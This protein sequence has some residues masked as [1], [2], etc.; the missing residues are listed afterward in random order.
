MD[1]LCIRCK[2]KGLCGKRCKILSKFME[3]TPK[4]KTHFSGSSPP[5]VFVG[6]ASYPNVFSGILSPTIKGNTEFMSS[7][8]IWVEKNLSI[9][10]VLELR[11]QMIYGR[12][13]GN[14]HAQR[15]SANVTQEIAMA[16]KPVSAEYFLKREPKQEFSL[17]KFFSVIGNPAPIQKVLLEE[18]P[19]IDKKIDYLVSDYDVKTSVAIRELYDSQIK[20]NSIQKIFSVGLLGVKTDRKLV[21]TR[22]SI[23]AVDDLISKQILEKVKTFQELNEILIFSDTYNG[24]HYEILFLPGEF[25]F[26]V[27]EAWGVGNVYGNTKIELSADHEGFYGRKDYA[28]SV[29]GAYY[30]NRLAVAE[31]LKKIQK[32][33]NVL[34]LREISEDY[35]APLG[36]GILREL[37]RKA[38][39]KNPQKANSIAEALAIVGKRFKFPIEEFSK[40]S[41]L[42]N[43]YGKQ[44]KIAEFI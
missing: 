2:G 23:T 4:I 22:W 14:V 43:E 44:K 16:S 36:V 27:L 7:P 37:S 38:L 25:K 30:A 33:A 12:Q 5:E 9:E 29:T 40:K 11:G 24:N 26:E 32:Q 1:N 21:P 31:F 35:Y 39:T 17:S 19:K 41:F 20:V 8:E 6:R 42:L 28:N 3:N 10:K 15:S 13:I 34:V 18:N